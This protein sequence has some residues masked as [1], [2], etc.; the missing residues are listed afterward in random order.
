MKAKY[1]SLKHSSTSFLVSRRICVTG[2]TANI[3]QPIHFYYI[4]FY[5]T[6]PTITRPLTFGDQDRRQPQQRFIISMAR[7]NIHILE[8]TLFGGALN[9]YHYYRG[10]ASRIN[11]SGQMLWHCF[12]GR[13]NI[14][15]LRANLQEIMNRAV[16]GPALLY[17]QEIC[18][19]FGQGIALIRTSLRAVNVID[20]FA[21]LW[22]T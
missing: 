21:I 20:F 13:E 2:N 18:A 16:T 8:I 19:I 6:T 4:L 10:A 14:P 5:S 9:T 12:N 7:D 3:P 17:S 11:P 15:S 1:S 22:R